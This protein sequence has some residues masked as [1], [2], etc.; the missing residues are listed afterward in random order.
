M[1]TVV[2]FAGTDV[3]DHGIQ[4][5]IHHWQKGIAKSDDCLEKRCLVAENLFYQIALFCCLYLM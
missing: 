2:T 5:L 3:Y 1:A 4:A